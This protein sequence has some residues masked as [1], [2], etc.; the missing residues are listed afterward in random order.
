VDESFECNDL[1]SNFYWEELNTI[2]TAHM[3]K[4]N[5]ATNIST[6]HEEE[7][8]KMKNNESSILRPINKKT[9]E[10]NL[11]SQVKDIVERH[12]TIRQ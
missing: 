12:V 8:S 6:I 10:K 4:I 11:R 9:L 3:K 2:G 7:M 5:L 1:S